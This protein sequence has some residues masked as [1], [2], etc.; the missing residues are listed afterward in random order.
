SLAKREGRVKDYRRLRSL[1]G[2][3][4]RRY[5]KDE[6][7]HERG[8]QDPVDALVFASHGQQQRRGQP[9]ILSHP[10]DHIVTSKNKSCGEDEELMMDNLDFD[11]MSFSST[12][13]PTLSTI[14]F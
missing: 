8:P 12:K 11:Q 1:R 2:G 14:G 10:D 9:A 13:R 5:S 7:G 6:D 3:L 4:Q